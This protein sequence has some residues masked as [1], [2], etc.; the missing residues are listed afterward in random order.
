MKKL[1]LFLFGICLSVLVSAQGPTPDWVAQIGGSGGEVVVQ[2]VASDAA[3]NVYLGGYFYGNVNFNP[4]TSGSSFTFDTGG[5]YWGFVAKYGNSGT[6]VWVK[7][8]GSDSEAGINAITIDASGNVYFTG[9][10]I[11]DAIIDGYYEY[12]D[13]LL[14]YGDGT[15]YDALLGQFDNLG[16]ISWFYSVGSAGDDEGYD[17]TLSGSSLYVTGDFGDQASFDNN[18]DTE[19]T[20]GGQDAFLASYDLI[21][22]FNWVRTLGS[23]D[24]DY[25]EAVTVGYNGVYVGGTFYAGNFDVDIGGG[26]GALPNDGGGDGFV[27]RYGTDGAFNMAYSIASTDDDAVRHLAVDGSENLYVGG[28]FSSNAG[29]VTNDGA[30][31]YTNVNRDSN[32]GL[33]AFVAKYDASAFG[34]GND[35]PYVTWIKTFGGTGDDYL[36]LVRT[37]QNGNVYASGAFQGDV[38]FNQGGTT[39]SSETADGQDGY[40]LGLTS[41]GNLSFVEQITGQGD[42]EG[43]ALWVNYP[44]L[45]VGGLFHQEA[46]VGGNYFGASGD[47]DGYVGRYILNP[48]TQPTDLLFSSETD[49]SFYYSFSPTTGVSGYLLV[50]KSGTPSALVPE[51]GTSYYDGEVL[52]DGSVVEYANAPLSATIASLYPGT[53][54]YVQ[55]YAFNYDGNGGGYNYLT[56][57]PLAG[58]VTTT[59]TPLTTTPSSQPSNL[60]FN[61]NGGSTLTVSFDAASDNPTNYLVLRSTDDYSTYVPIDGTDYPEGNQFGD[62]TV[63]YSGSATSFDDDVILDGTVYYYT[64]YSFNY[65]TSADLNRFLTDNPLQGHTDDSPADFQVDQSPESVDT[66]N[67]ITITAEIS[68]S[69]S[70]LQYVAMLVSSPDTE[71]ENEE[72]IDAFD[73]SG[74]T[75]SFSIPSTDIGPSGVLYYFYGDNG[76]GIRQWSND[77]VVPLNTS[78]I[79]IPF[80]ASGTSQTSYRIISIPVTTTDESVSGLFGDDL[81]TADKSKWRMFH[82]QGG[83]NVE[84]SGSSQMSAG[85][86]YWLIS[87]T[88]VTLDVPAGTTRKASYYDG[89]HLT[90]ESGWNQIGNPYLFDM[91]WADIISFNQTNDGLGSQLGGLRTYNGSWNDSN[92]L[93]EFGGAFVFVSGG[94]S[95]DFYIPNYKNTDITGRKAAPDNGRQSIDSDKWQVLLSADNGDIHYDLGGFGMNPDAKAGFD[96]FD[97]VNLPRFMDYI[98]I[99]HKGKSVQ[100]YPISKD[101]VPTADNHIWEFTVETNGIYPDSELKWDNTYFGNG[102]KELVLWDEALQKPVDMRTNSHYLFNQKISGKFKVLYGSGDFIKENTHVNDLLLQAVFP[103]PVVDHMTV[104]FSLPAT[105]D[106][107]DIALYDMLGQRIKT[108]AQGPFEDGYHEVQWSTNDTQ[109]PVSGL[110]LLQIRTRDARAVERV[111]FQ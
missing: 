37:D 65:S 64:V 45:A 79:T 56:D 1:L 110:Y 98:E 7:P 50:C 51:D 11:Y 76:A 72:E 92:L 96:Q 40:V 73:V 87:S 35:L 81:G 82:Y 108:V 5:Y 41:D 4:A 43:S 36:D 77:Y 97:E 19:Y 105:D 20:Q 75:Y 90:L 62:A 80:D 83:S 34:T 59:G 58:N 70:G 32:G 78:T 67:D 39:A 100:G 6:P 88:G 16:N 12:Y 61:Y 104:S 42:Q 27:A 46:T 24:N 94:S 13:N 63:A 86:G 21:G 14:Y 84:M 38:D 102:D 107:V 95:V 17:I 69:E 28:T 23:T 30:G 93:P 25:G 22:N 48:V 55:V 29:W 68:D 3:G 66:G 103:N 57:T 111:V 26:E 8:I 106:H 33:D 60:Q 49:N 91:S 109:R 54:Y 31:S 85:E 53:T 52:Q 18:A 2:S 44:D 99:D 15:D 71:Y 101:I 10:M 47:P 89:I 74:N 9:Y